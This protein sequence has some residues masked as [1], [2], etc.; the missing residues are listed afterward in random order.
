MKQEQVCGHFNYERGNEMIELFMFLSVFD[1]CKL[2]YCR[3]CA[4]KVIEFLQS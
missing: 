2:G 1:K 4:L 3:N